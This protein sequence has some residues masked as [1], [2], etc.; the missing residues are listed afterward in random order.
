[1][2]ILH[3]HMG[4][5]LKILGILAGVLIFYFILTQIVYSLVIL[6]SYAALEQEEATEDV[7][8]CLDALQREIKYLETVTHDWAA[9]DDTYQFV[10]EENESYRRSNLL[11]QTFLDN[12]I[13]AILFLNLRKEMIWGEV[14]SLKNGNPIVLPELSEAALQDAPV[15]FASHDGD[16]GVSGIMQTSVGP[17]IL[18]SQPITTSDHQGPIRGHLIMGRFFDTDYIERLKDQTHIDHEYLPVSEHKTIVEK[19]LSDENNPPTIYFAVKNQAILNGFT[20]IR[21][22]YGEP[23]LV[24]RTT[25]LRHIY[26][27]GSETLRLALISIALAG[28]V[29]LIL[30]VVLINNTVIGPPDINFSVGKRA[31]VQYRQACQGKSR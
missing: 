9:W 22:I 29:I 4:I 25:L 20:V 16:G 2:A 5:R 21:D 28:L 18:S 17:F 8:R 31:A 3:G 10:Q 27:K 24:L 11:Q 15:L 13:N 6:P 7:H 1:M 30:M 23:A 12:R 26:A 19:C 14:R